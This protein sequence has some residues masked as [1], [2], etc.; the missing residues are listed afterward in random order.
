MH[1]EGLAFLSRDI[2]DFSAW[3]HTQAHPLPLGA[4]LPNIPSLTHVFAVLP[5]HILVFLPSGL[6]ELVL[7]QCGRLGWI[8][9]TPPLSAIPYI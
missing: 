5:A 7:V 4:I 6:T 1:T 9:I 2:A 8:P 3:A